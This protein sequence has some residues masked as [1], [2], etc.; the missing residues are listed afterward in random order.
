MKFKVKVLIGYI[1]G[2]MMVFEYI[3]NDGVVSFTDNIDK[4]PEEYLPVVTE[5]EVDTIYT[6]PRYSGPCDDKDCN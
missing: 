4:V 1:V 3:T 6:Y 5:R 2:V